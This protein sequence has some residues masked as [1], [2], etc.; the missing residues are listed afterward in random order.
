MHRGA[1]LPFLSGHAVELPTPE[2]VHHRGQLTNATVAN[3]RSPVEAACPR[4]GA[5][6]ATRSAAGK[7]AHFT[8]IRAVRGYT[9]FDSVPRRSVRG[10]AKS[11]ERWMRLGRER[12]CRVPRYRGGTGESTGGR[13]AK[14]GRCAPGTD[15]APARAQG[16]EGELEPPPGFDASRNRL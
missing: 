11:R 8:I 3:C 4:N 2:R 10:W 12:K 9:R 16:G 13:T 14:F 5:G 15:E 1:A 7:H 6:A